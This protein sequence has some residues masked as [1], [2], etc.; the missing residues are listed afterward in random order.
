MKKAFKT[1]IILLLLGALFFIGW[2]TLSHQFKV[3]DTR[4]LQTLKVMTYNTHR[5]GEFLHPQQN[6][7]IRFLQ[8]QDADIVCLQEVEVYHDANYLTLLELKEALHK[9]PYTYFD[10]KVFNSRR[11]FGNAVFSRYPLIN[12][13]TIRYD[14]RSSISSR[15]DVVV[16]KDTLRLIN[17]H[18]E[19]NRLEQ[20]DFAV[21]S[22]TGNEIKSATQHV[23]TKMR[24]ARQIRHEQA[25]AVKQAIR[26]S[27]HPVIVAGDFNSVPLS[28]VYQKIKWGL[29]DT[30]LET[31]KWKMGHTFAKYHI[32]IRIDY[33]LCSKKLTPVSSEVIKVNYSD[34]Y[35]MV[36]TIGWAPDNDNL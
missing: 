10:F 34:H 15:C 27:S 1:I 23:W 16:G 9:Y 21:D 29:R 8:E 32:G 6:R 25:K 3:R 12:K 26:Q 30:F 35:P 36:S 19:S 33:I 22:L 4:G 18:L 11:Q 5:M 24:A 20:H 14:S 2:N 28:Y 7:V 31:S 17:N 13:E